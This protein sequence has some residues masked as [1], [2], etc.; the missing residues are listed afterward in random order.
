MVAVGRVQ[1][2]AIACSVRELLLMQK[3]SI[4]LNE[5]EQF[6]IVRQELSND[7]DE[8]ES[9]SLDDQ[10]ALIRERF[11]SYKHSGE[12]WLRKDWIDLLNRG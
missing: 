11:A 12:Q 8:F 9:F 1:L 6:E 3:S 10:V 2:P 5:F 4:Y 7:I